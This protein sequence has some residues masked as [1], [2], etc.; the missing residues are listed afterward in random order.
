MP[1]ANYQDFEIILER[2]LWALK[3][4]P[5][6]VMAH[7]KEHR[8]D[9]FH[10]IPNPKNGSFLI[11]GAEVTERF[12]T[13]AKRH[14]AS[15][16]D[17]NTRTNLESFVQQLGKKFSEFFLQPE[18]TRPMDQQNMDRWIG[19]ALRATMKEHD[20][21]T[22]YIPC[23][24]LFSKTVKQFN[25]GPVSFYHSDEFFR[26]YGE[27]IERLRESIRTHHQKRIEEAIKKGFP[28]KNASTPEQ[29]AEWGHHLTDGLLDFY[30][31]FNWFAAVQIAASDKEVSYDRALFITRGALNII[32]LF[33]GAGYT[34]RVRTADDPGN[35]GPAATLRRNSKGE[36]NISLS[37]KPIDNV[38]G[39]DWIEYLTTGSA[40]FFDY[41]TRALDLCST[42]EEPPPLCTRFMDA[43]HWFGEAVAEK[44]S[45]APIV[46]CVT[47]IERICGTG[48][49]KDSL[50][51]VRGV[52]DIVTSRAA[53]L[54]SVLEQVPFNQARDE[55][56][57]IYD[58]RSD[59]VHGSVSPSDENIGMK[60]HRTHEI[61]RSVL[62]AALDYYSTLGFDNPA[63]NT[64]GLRAAFKKLEQWNADGR[65]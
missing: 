38:G 2:V 42:F 24:L 20:S 32:K 43:L 25:V 37:S 31:R 6:E 52:T 5:E 14:L 63:L 10:S 26:L 51:N 48:I 7:V 64:S 1:S 23:A 65:P 11:V 53:I 46:K 60:V 41:A 47:A 61:T 34:D 4:T 29:S 3:L 40:P 44:S 30:K 50:G 57:D 54:Y 45:A 35:S 59:L 58:C 17:Q 19:S 39:D 49:E 62:F 12:R 13:I 21:A 8:M 27:E 33:L 18:Q 9:A 36:L 16:P 28:K 22:H 55:I 56:T 15:H